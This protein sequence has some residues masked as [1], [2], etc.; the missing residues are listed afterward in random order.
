MWCWGFL[1]GASFWGACFA[2]G[3]SSFWRTGLAPDMQAWLSVHGLMEALYLCSFVLCTAATKCLSVP[4]GGSGRI[5]CGF[6]SLGWLWSNCLRLFVPCQF[7]P[8]APCTCCIINTGMRPPQCWFGRMYGLSCVLSS[9]SS[10][11]GRPIISILI[12]AAVCWDA[13]THARLQTPRLYMSWINIFFIRRAIV[14]TSAVL[15]IIDA[16]WPASGVC[17]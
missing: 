3:L 11:F 9:A 13:Y 4:N 17:H 1:F 7:Q 14:I 16:S 8:G 6:M 12:S 2:S 10:S 5:R 15:L